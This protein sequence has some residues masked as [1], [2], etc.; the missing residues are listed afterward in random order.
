MSETKGAT[1][2][3]YLRTPEA[4]RFLGLSD[5]TMEK[6]RSYGTGPVYM[7]IGG[8]V[9]YT[10]AD[11]QAW[12]QRGVRSSTSDPNAQIVPAAKR[13]AAVAPAFSANGRSGK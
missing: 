1:P 5:R 9:V 3:R 4:A 7:K 8:R 13:H 11:L 12:S 10:L 2:P 6:H